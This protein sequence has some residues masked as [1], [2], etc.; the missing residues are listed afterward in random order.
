MGWTLDTV[1]NAL[2]LVDFMRAQYRGR[3]LRDRRLIRAFYRATLRTFDSA[4]E[5]YRWHQKI[6]LETPPGNDWRLRRITQTLKLHNELSQAIGLRDT[7][8]CPNLSVRLRLRLA[9]M[10]L[11]DLFETLIHVIRPFIERLWQVQKHESLSRVTAGPLLDRFDQ[12]APVTMQ[13]II[14]QL[15]LQERNGISHADYDINEDGSSVT[16]HDRRKASSDKPIT[17]SNEQ[18]RQAIDALYVLTNVFV[19]QWIWVLSQAVRPELLQ[20][21]LG[22]R[23]GF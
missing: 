13:P 10:I 6:G 2:K 11:A 17:L 16:L 19:F 8:T 14:Q 5:A 4:I 3:Y 23:R 9:A 1:A 20:I 18:I 21:R 7:P 12:V 22:L 15:R